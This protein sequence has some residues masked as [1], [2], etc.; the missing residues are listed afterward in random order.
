MGSAGALNCSPFCRYSKGNIAHAPGPRRENR[1]SR[2][3]AAH[4]PGKKTGAATVNLRCLRKPLERYVGISR[5]S[6]ENRERGGRSKP[7]PWLLLRRFRAFLGMS[8]AGRRRSGTSEL[9]FSGPKPVRMRER[10]PSKVTSR[11]ERQRLPHLYPFGG[12]TAV[13]GRLLRRRLSYPVDLYIISHSTMPAKTI[14]GASYAFSQTLCSRAT[15]VM[16]PPEKS[17]SAD[18]PCPRRLVGLYYPA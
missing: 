12:K 18:S 3:S 16:F 8:C 10:S 15:I 11:I 9:S 5:P 6:G 17:R 4:A 1:T 7:T 14:T 13:S 2:G